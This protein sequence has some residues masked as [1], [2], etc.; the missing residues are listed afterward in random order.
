[1][2]DVHTHILPALDDGARTQEEAALLMEMEEK[3]G[4]KEVVFTPHYYGKKRSLEQ[5]LVLREEAWSKLRPY[6]P[7]GVKKR[8][9]AEVHLTGVNDP[10]DDALCALSIEGTSCVLVEFPFYTKWPKSLFVRLSRFIADTG[11]TPIVA[12]AERYRELLKN[13]SV[14]TR[15]VEMGCL[16][17]LN[18]R[19][20][21]EKTTRRFAFA[22]LKNGLVHCLGT[23][24]HDTD[25]RAPDYQAARETVYAAGYG[26][27][28][29]RVQTCM[30]DILDK[31]RVRQAYKPVRKFFC[32]YF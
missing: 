22:M 29:Q 7:S 28:W 9:G 26:D 8:L 11:Y 3:Q 20:F 13:P 18:T 6:M 30:R 19:A 14:A 23:D 21:L 2:I 32:R 10:S 15:L 31:R 12:H 25:S 5:F 16:I 17:Q 24:T 27:K 4:V 1:M